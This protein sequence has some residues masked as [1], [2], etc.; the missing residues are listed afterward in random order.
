MNEIC[1]EEME[2]EEREKGIETPYG[3]DK[4]A[5]LFMPDPS[6]ATT[7]R[8]CKF[9]TD[10]RLGSKVVSYYFILDG[11]ELSSLNL[12]KKTLHLSPFIKY[13]KLFFFILC[14]LYNSPLS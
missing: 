3:L 14:L 8:K 10:T 1:F 4:A 11:E 2:I 6:P 5:V 9:G 12:I 13:I 7:N